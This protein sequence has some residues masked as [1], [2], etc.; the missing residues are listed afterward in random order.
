MKKR[1]QITEDSMI[2]CYNN[3][4]LNSDSDDDLTIFPDNIYNKIQDSFL[5]D[6]LNF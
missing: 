2:N 3:L 5:E 1:H 4:K 6:V